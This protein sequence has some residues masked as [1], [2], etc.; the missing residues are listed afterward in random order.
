MTAQIRPNRMEVSDRF[1]MLGFAVRTDQPDVEAEVVIASDIGLFSPQKRTARTAANF[2]S[3]REHGMLRVPRGEGVFVVPPEVLARFIGNERLFF[4]LATGHSGNGGLRVDALPR[5]GSPYVSLRGFTGRTLRRGFGAAPATTP[6]LEWTGD[7]PAPGSEQS[8]TGS[9]Q[10]AQGTVNGSGGPTPAPAPYDDGFGPMPNIPARESAFRGSVPQR[11]YGANRV[12]ITMDAGTTADS[13]IAWLREKIEQG[14]QAAGSAVSPPS[15]YYLGDASGTF[16]TA[17]Q[18]VFGVTS[19]FSP[20]NAFLAAIPSLAR[21]LDVTLS[22]GPALDTPLFGGGVGAVFAP[23]GQVGLFGQGE[24]SADLDSLTEFAKSLKLALAAKMKLGYN[25][26]G[27]ASFADIRTIAGV[28]VG[29]EIV[30]G[31]ELW[32]DSS[33][34]GIGGAVS[35][36]VG[37]ALQLAAQ[38]AP[39]RPARFASARQLGL[40]ADT[41]AIT[42]SGS[43]TARQAL[44][45]IMEK[46]EQIVGAVGDDVS[47]PS[48]YRL[49]SNSSAFVSAWETVLGAAGWLPGGAISSFLAEL[50]GIAR[51]TNVTLSIGPAL[52]TPLFGGGVGVVFAP[53]G[54]VALFGQGD[55]SVDIEGLTEFVSSLKA[56]LQAKLKL[57]YN[58]GGIDGFA[59]LRKVGG[60]AVG[61]EI[62]VGAE[63]WLDGSGSGIGG[64]VSIGVGFAL[65][66][67]AEMQQ[68]RALPYRSARAVGLPRSTTAITMSSGTSARQALDW[69]LHKVEQI[70]DLVGD[71]V[72]PPSLYRLGSDSSTFISAWETVLG[73]AGWL[74]GGAV[75][76]FLAEIPALARSASVTVSIGPALDTPLFGGGVGVVFAPDGQVALFG[77]GDISVDFEGLSEFASSLKA[78]LQAKLKLGYNRGGLDGFASL[79]KV[80]SVAVGE[81]IVV[82]AEVWL[83]GSGS[84]IGGAVSI[85]VGFALQLAA[86]EAENAAVM[87]V[88]PGD[89]RARAT[90]IGGE[91]GPRIAEALDLGLD[92][93]SIL[94]LL[95]KLDPP[96][97]PPK[98]ELPTPAPAPAVQQAFDRNRGGARPEL[99]E[100]RQHARGMD[101]GAIA[102]IAGTAVTLIAGSSGGDI[103]WRLPQWT[104]YKHPNDQR[105]ANDATYRTSVIE[106]EDGPK[107]AGCY[108]HPKIRW[109]YNG[110]SIGP[111]YVERGHY[112]DTVGWGATT[113]GIIQ[114]VPQTQARDASAVVQGENW[115]AALDVVLTYDF[116]APPMTDDPSATSRIRL[117]GDGTYEI[118]TKW[119]EHSDTGFTDFTEANVPPRNRQPIDA[120]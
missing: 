116:Q 7:A 77:Q 83:D 85:G 107:A 55:I 39:L 58:R 88:L 73:A 119:D 114:D 4:G 57:G 66:L 99:S 87:P 2:Y 6:S 48:L 12:G 101:A 91:F 24:I 8:N 102:T 61:E 90:R 52:D 74:P 18:V 56:A 50:P 10:P 49:G 22:I 45:W 115:V 16:T 59:S 65:Q 94:P 104:G 3:S 36:G 64:A 42:M 15:I 95:D 51:A 120:I 19:L 13:A 44:D 108:A 30:G 40:P 34:S 11:S 62:V 100:L 103:D 110:T 27:L 112:N 118:T 5:E 63:I 80:G 54:Q 109:S 75:A 98:P 84:G 113:S 37:F 111:V 35:I 97:A 82:G 20:V 89:P 92:A 47:P 32:L 23:D 43:T 53:D 79:R 78:S 14:V 86:Q 1:P 105:P 68:P 67:A 96:V 81:E 31:S 21:R 60:V 41:T 17:W 29:E 93:G 70:V 25:R 28:M 9:V 26:G 76:G 117:F 71:D 72:S 46:V 38:N 69:I 106:L 33:G